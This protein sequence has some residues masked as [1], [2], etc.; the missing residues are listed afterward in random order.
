MKELLLKSHAVITNL[1]RSVEDLE[2]ENERMREAIKAAHEALLSTQELIS[3]N[4]IASE[5]VME[6]LK[7]VIK[8]HNAKVRKAI[9]LTDVALPKLQSFLTEPK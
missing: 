1:L 6:C 7:P 3:N 8:R 5:Q 9:D 4:D 2:K